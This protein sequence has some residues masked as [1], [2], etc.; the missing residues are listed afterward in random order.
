LVRL[1]VGESGTDP[2][3][4]RL[5]KHGRA[6]YAAPTYLKKNGMPTK[7]DDLK[8][9]SL[10]TNTSTPSYNQWSFLIAGK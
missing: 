4:T 9:H 7:P 8:S 1:P 10:I 3:F 6:L 2:D 5:G